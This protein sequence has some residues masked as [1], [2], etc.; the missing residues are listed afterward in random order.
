MK[1]TQLYLN[2]DTHSILTALSKQKKKTISYLVREALA[3]KYGKKEKID[4]LDLSKKISGIWKNRKDMVNSERYLRK[5]RKDTR[6]KRF[7][8]E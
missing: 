8:I 6:R 7:R 3:E 4:K 2:E 1:R 5:L